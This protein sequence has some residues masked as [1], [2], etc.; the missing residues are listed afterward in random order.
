[1]LKMTQ[2]MQV[3]CNIAGLKAMSRGSVR[4]HGQS[5]TELSKKSFLLTSL[6]GDQGCLAA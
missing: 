3:Q 4:G 6:P 2:R 5:P 1:M